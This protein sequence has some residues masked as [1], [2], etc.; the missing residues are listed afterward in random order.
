MIYIQHWKFKTGFH[1]QAAKK[2]LAT[3]AP[4]PRA[5]MLGRYHGPGSL[6][7]WILVETADPT[8]LYEHAADWGEFMEWRRLQYL[9]MNKPDL[10]WRKFM[11]SD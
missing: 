5:N 4:Y 1:E 11:A 3:Q 6:E 8:A 10:L 9:Q 2:F 7:G